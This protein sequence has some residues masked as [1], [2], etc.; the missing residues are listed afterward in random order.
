MHR[1]LECRSRESIHGVNTTRNIAVQCCRS[2]KTPPPSCIESQLVSVGAAAIDQHTR[3]DAL[4]STFPQAWRLSRSSRDSDPVVRRYGLASLPCSRGVLLVTGRPTATATARATR[5][6]SG[7]G[8]ERR[9]TRREAN[10]DTSATQVQAR[11][12]PLPL[13]TRA[14]DTPCPSCCRCPPPWPRRAW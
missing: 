12:P 13:P 3:L 8:E 10:D 14:D 1:R 11:Q 9:T 4:E 2:R 5:S 6:G 7:R